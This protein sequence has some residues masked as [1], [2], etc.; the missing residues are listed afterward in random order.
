MSMLDIADQ[1]C[2]RSYIIIINPISLYVKKFLYA[3][4]P[5]LMRKKVLV[6]GKKGTK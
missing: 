4:L 2:F 3:Y 5:N 6:F 1:F